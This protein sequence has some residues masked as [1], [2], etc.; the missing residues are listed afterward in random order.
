MILYSFIQHGIVW[1][2]RI[3]HSWL[4]T[5]LFW[6]AAMRYPQL[7]LHTLLVCGICVGAQLLTVDSKQ[8]VDC[9]PEPGALA[10]SC[11]NR[12]CIWDTQQYPVTKYSIWRSLIYKRL[13]IIPDWRC[14]KLA[15]ND[16]LSSFSDIFR[17]PVDVSKTWV[18]WVFPPAQ[19]LP[20]FFLFHIFIRHLSITSNSITRDASCIVQPFKNFRTR[21]LIWFLICGEPPQFHASSPR[22][23][24]TTIFHQFYRSQQFF[25]KSYGLSPVRP[26][27][28]LEQFQK[29]NGSSINFLFIFENIYLRSIPS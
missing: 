5:E 14:F 22:A 24:T 16:P 2:H 23:E 12:S 6:F 27:R 26:M 15:L 19:L 21:P 11:A 20:Y 17:L 7:S 25:K 13:R 1:K 29:L 10:H 9:F 4:C 8:R 3:I 28:P 18:T